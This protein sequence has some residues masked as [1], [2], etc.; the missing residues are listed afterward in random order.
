M[1]RGPSQLRPFKL[2]RLYDQITP[3]MVAEVGEQADISCL[4]R[5]ADVRMPVVLASI[6]CSHI[7]DGTRR[8]HKMA[9]LYSL[10][11]S[12]S[13]LYGGYARSVQL[14]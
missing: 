3:A 7:G 9:N 5:Q 2:E 13:W 4:M 8:Q 11:I 12:L 14:I 6:G 1:R 10:N